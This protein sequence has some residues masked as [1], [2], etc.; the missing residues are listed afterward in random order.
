MLRFVKNRPPKA[1]HSIKQ[2]QAC[3]TDLPYET[4]NDIIRLRKRKIGTRGVL[5]ERELW[6]ERRSGGLP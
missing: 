5:I 2:T 6:T 4:Q 1:T 3:L